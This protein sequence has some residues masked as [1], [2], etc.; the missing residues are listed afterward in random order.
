[1]KNLFIENKNVETIEIMIDQ[2]LN[3]KIATE[4][5][6]CDSDSDLIID[7]TNQKIILNVDSDFDFIDQIN[8]KII[9]CVNFAFALKSIIDTNFV[10]IL[11]IVFE[12]I[13][14]DF[15]LTL[16]IDTSKKNA[17]VKNMNFIIVFSV[18]ENLTSIINIVFQTVAPK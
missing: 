13:I 16:K 1:M 12:N 6:N 10:F 5:L 14:F 9:L 2:N 4:N 15:R 17:I 8:R 11:K 7:S 18:A 3:Q